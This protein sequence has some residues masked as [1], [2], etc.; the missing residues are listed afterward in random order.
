[1]AKKLPKTPK[2]KKIPMRT[3][4][5]TG[6]SFPKRELLR[7]T[8]T[9]EGEISIDPTGRAHGRGGY[10]GLTIEEAKAAKA[11][12]VFNRAFSAEI[13]T[14]FYDEVIAY[15]TKEVGRRAL[16]EV[17]YSAESAPDYD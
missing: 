4:L 14:D 8:Y 2:P 10:I 11:K 6:T 16:E 13:S 15:V 1:M 5:A 3:S 12:K 9:K 7:I 17:V